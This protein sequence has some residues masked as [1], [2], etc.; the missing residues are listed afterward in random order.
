MSQGIDNWKSLREAC[1]EYGVAP[2]NLP[3]LLKRIRTPKVDTL[4]DI[5]DRLAEMVE[6]GAHPGSIAWVLKNQI[7]CE[8]QDPAKCDHCRGWAPLEAVPVDPFAGESPCL[9]KEPIPMGDP[10]KPYPADALRRCSK[11]RGLIGLL[12]R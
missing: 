8:E 5:R 3:A 6:A 9:C 2:L 1:T 7:V 11:C 4:G 10:R 12:I